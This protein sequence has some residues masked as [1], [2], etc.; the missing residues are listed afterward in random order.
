MK[1][2]IHGRGYVIP[3]SLHVVPAPLHVIPAPL[4]VIPD[5]IRDPVTSAPTG[6]L[7]HT[8]FRHSPE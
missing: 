4:H 2:V 5:L 8:G 6:G 7:Q 3:D 1:R